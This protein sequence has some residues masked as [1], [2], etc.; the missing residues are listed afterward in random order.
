MRII[1]SLVTTQVTEVTID[2]APLPVGGI[3]VLPGTA[4]VGGAL[5]FG[6]LGRILT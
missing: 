5:I 1:L 6:G 2:V 4:G 3:I